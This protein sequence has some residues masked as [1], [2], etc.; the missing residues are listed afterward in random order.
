MSPR[1]TRGGVDFIVNDTG[2]LYTAQTASEEQFRAS[3]GGIPVEERDRTA[4]ADVAA[5]LVSARRAAV[6]LT[7]YPGALPTDLSSAYARQAATLA[8]WPASDPVAGWKVARIGADWQARFPE[9]RLIGPILLRNVHRYSAG[10]VL[11]CPVFEGGFAAV[12]AEIGVFVASDTPPS[13]TEWTAEAAADWVGSM[14]V[15]V[16]IA[17]SPLASINDLGPGAVIS[18][19]GNNWGGIAGASVAD[20]RT[21][22]RALVV[23]TRIDNVVVGS[24]SIEIPATTL[25]A[26]AFALGK[27]AKLG[28]PLRAGQYISC[29]MITGVHDIRV[30]QSARVSFGE[31]GEAG[32]ILCRIVPARPLDS[33]ERA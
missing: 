5:Q 9:E 10:E 32:E 31:R 21:R 14:C 8:R 22:A 20:W 4:V 11:D 33:A 25:G 12:E 7:E 2:F 17:S 19:F 30:G 23:T 13:R 3:A 6:P 29:G 16:E 28:R 18:D 15:G 1:A 27:A 24:A 26:F